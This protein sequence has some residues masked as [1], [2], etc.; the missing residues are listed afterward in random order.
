M[1]QFEKDTHLMIGMFLVL[2]PIS[3]K[4]PWKVKLEIRPQKAQITLSPRDESCER[5]LASESIIDPP[6]NDGGIVGFLGG[7]FDRP[8]ANKLIYIHRLIQGVTTRS[9]IISCIHEGPRDYSL[10]TKDGPMV[11]DAPSLSKICNFLA[12]SSQ[13]STILLF[14]NWRSFVLDYFVNI[15]NF[16]GILRS[17]IHLWPFGRRLN[18]LIPYSRLGENL[19]RDF[20]E[21]S[22]NLHVPDL[23]HMPEDKLKILSA[24]PLGWRLEIP[25]WNSSLTSVGGPCS[26]SRPIKP[27]YELDSFS[28]AQMSFGTGRP[29]YGSSLLQ[30]PA[31]KGFSSDFLRLTDWQVNIHEHTPDEDRKMCQ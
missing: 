10:T 25:F 3:D 1:E 5:A 23:G 17:I 2:Y 19:G 4:W 21:K 15:R 11:R 16:E 26:F 28:R 27:R 12:N 29:S 9:L 13:N 24:R 7:N 14:G 31:G 30:E 6:V 20:D 22:K 18:N 8:R